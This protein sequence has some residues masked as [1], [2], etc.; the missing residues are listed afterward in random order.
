MVDI[1]EHLLLRSAEAR[2]K[3]QAKAYKKETKSL[4]KQY[5]KAAKGVAKFAAKKIAKIEKAKA[6]GDELWVIVNSDLQ[7]KLKGSKEFM[8]EKETMGMGSRKA[9][10]S[11]MK[12]DHR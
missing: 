11:G 10:D 3:A 7:R 2:A 8:D 12:K 9:A 1:P 6:K 4:R 5:L